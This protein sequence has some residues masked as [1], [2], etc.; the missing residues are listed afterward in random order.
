MAKRRIPGTGVLNALWGA[1]QVLWA[2]LNPWFRSWR[3][4]WGATPS[5]V[6]GALPG[7]DLVP[8]PR[9]SY[10]HAI[11][12]QAPAATVFPWLKQIGARRGG[13]YSFQ[14]LENLAG[15]KVRDPALAHIGRLTTLQRLEI[16][17]TKITDKGLVHLRGLKNLLVLG[18]SNTKIT[19][20]KYISTGYIFLFNLVHN[21]FM[22]TVCVAYKNHLFFM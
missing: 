11:T 5:E 7:D 16:F 8:A 18:L 14:G 20:M 17:N 22:V 13:F 10:T 21:K 12:I 9:W 4:R 6:A 1:L 2:L 15:C 3:T 19:D